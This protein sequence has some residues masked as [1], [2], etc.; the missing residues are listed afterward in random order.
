M[1]K[2]S[3]IIGAVSLSIFMMFFYG[4]TQ[5]SPKIVF[6]DVN[7]I[8]QEYPKMVELNERYKAD[9]QY[10]QNKLNELTKELENM[11]KS[12]ASQ[13]DIEK[14]QNEILTRRQQYEQLLQN[15]YQPK[16]QETLNEIAD[17]IDKYAKMMG[18]DYIMN[19]Q[20]LVY[21]DDAYDITDQLVKFLKAQ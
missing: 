9:F 3:I 6:V 21:G 20:M 1:K 17:K 16:M 2:V 5:E 12:G 13:T 11:Q 7:R 10:Y 19:K 15:E 14:K 18:Y 8:T 4:A